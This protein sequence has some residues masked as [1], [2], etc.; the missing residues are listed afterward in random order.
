[1]ALPKTWK[2]LFANLAMI[3]FLFPIAHRG[4]LQGANAQMENKPD[5][6]QQAIDQFFDVEIDIRYIDGHFYLGHDTPQYEISYEWLYERRDS[7]WL[8]CKNAKA[9]HL[10]RESFNCFWQQ[11]DAYSL[12]SKN[13][14]W[15]N[16]G[17]EPMPG[18][19][20]VDLEK[21]TIQKR[22][23]WL[24][25]KCEAICTDYAAMLNK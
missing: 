14:L 2:L 13:K 10:L 1:L 8:H 22:V 15:V 21:P 17:R 11:D 12:T 4:N 18:C 6:I 9:L 16:I 25:Q 3:N 5:Y 19:V 7:L 20:L 24:E 23:Q